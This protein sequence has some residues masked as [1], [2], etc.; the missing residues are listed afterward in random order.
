MKNWIKKTMNCI[1]LAV[2]GFVCL[3]FFFQHKLIWLPR[4]YTSD[5]EPLTTAVALNYTTSQGFQRSFY[6]PPAANPS[7]SPERLWVLF[8]GNGSLALDW[9]DFVAL[10][11]DKHD[12]FLLFEY[13]GYGHCEGS[14][15]PANIKESSELALAQLARHLHMQPYEIEPKLNVIGHSIGCA[16]A[17]EF[18]TRHPV[19]RVILAAPFTSLREMARRTIGWPL[20]WLLL[21][22][23]DNRARL[24]E[25]A[26]RTIPP[27]ITI[28]HGSDDT[29]IPLQMG[30]SLA[31]MFPKMIAFHEVPQAGHNTIVDMAEAQIFAVMNE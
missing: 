26:S 23:F 27:H 3:L 10:A 30:K 16:S 24:A 29:L 6:I 2:A 17:L 12:G 1:I 31:A 15:T 7:A 13:P 28:F 18:A 19:Q 22:N 20:C 8:C 4:H 11:P 9:A 25:L 14:A 21:H 5:D